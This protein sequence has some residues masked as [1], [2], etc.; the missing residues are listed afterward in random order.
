MDDYLAW[1]IV[2][3]LLIILPME[4]VLII[5]T[6]MKMLDCKQ[7]LLTLLHSN[8]TTYVTK[9]AQIDNVNAKIANFSSLLYH[10]LLNY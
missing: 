8:M 6:R 5:L 10:N 9:A 7:N 3:I 2:I 1:V 4:C